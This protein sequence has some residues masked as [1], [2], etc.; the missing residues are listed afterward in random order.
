MWNEDPAHAVEDPLPH[1]DITA[2]LAR[3][4]RSSHALGAHQGRPKVLEV[5]QVWG[6]TLLDTRHFPAD[7]G[8]EVTLG[9]TVGHRWRVLGTDMGWVP[10]PLHL[11]LPWT[12]PGL[13]EVTSDQRWDFFGHRLRRPF[14]VEDG[15]WAAVIDPRWDGFA[16]VDGRRMSWTDLVSWGLATE[17]VDDILVPLNG[18]ERVLAAIDGQ[19]FLAH[20]VWD[21][22][23]LDRAGV[24][25][26]TRAWAGG[27][28]ASLLAVL[29]AVLLAQVP[30]R[31]TT[32]LDNHDTIV[33]KLAHAPPP[34]FIA[35]PPRAAGDAGG[36]GQ[37]QEATPDRTRPA[38]AGGQAVL[39]L[40][41]RFP[42]ESPE[43][44]DTLTRAVAGLR[45][46]HS[47]HGPA[48]AGRGA[49]FGHGGVAEG[50]GTDCCGVGFAGGGGPGRSH[51]PGKKDGPLVKTPLDPIVIGPVNKA[52]IQEVVMRHLNQIRHCYQRQLATHPDL[53]GTVKIRFTI[54]SDGS[55]SHA[56]VSRSSLQHPSVEDCLKDR[57]LRMRFPAPKGGG[58]VTVAYP[59]TF[60]TGG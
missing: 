44:K 5:S 6:Q 26:D 32:V 11:L 4:G 24:D 41:G 51:G 46:A 60:A 23:R 18:V 50:L 7:P 56:E 49:D 21:A 10:P 25:P 59:L 40:F 47:S 34:V 42:G 15:A 48:L 30:V 39:A 19:L 52:L 22:Q 33:A 31:E 20:L 43:L 9:P 35:P 3:A 37:R 2:L 38:P 8:R 54:A 12:A 27:A 36:S 29:V 45:N 55:V 17:E 16:E 53:Q 28:V 57:F 13:S 58:I 1:E 14:R